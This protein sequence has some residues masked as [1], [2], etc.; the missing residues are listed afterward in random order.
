MPMRRCVASVVSLLCLCAAGPAQ[1]Q[2]CTANLLSTADEYGIAGSQFEVR[3]TVIWD[4]DGAGPIQPVLVALAASSINSQFGQVSSA[5]AMWDGTRWTAVPRVG[6]AGQITLLSV[7][8][9]KLVVGGNFTTIDNVAANRIAVFDG[10]T[11]S[12]LAAGL[13]VVPVCALEHQGS[14]YV[15]GPF[16]TVGP[17]AANGIVRWDGAQWRS[18][19][20]GVG[21]VSPPQV[22]ALTVDGDTIIAAGIF[23]TAGAVVASSVAR[24]TPSLNAWQPV[25]VW[26]ATGRPTSV[27]VLNGDVYIAG[28]GGAVAPNIPGMLRLSGQ[29]WVPVPGFEG[30]S[31]A[32]SLTR[33]DNTLHIGMLTGS[34]DSAQT[35]YCRYDG[36]FFSHISPGASLDRVNAVTTFQDR[37]IVAGEF[38]TLGARGCSRNITALGPFGQEPLGQGLS[39]VATPHVRDLL[40]NGTDTYI[41]GDFTAIGGRNI[42]YLARR[43]AAGNYESLGIDY[44]VV[45]IL[46]WDENP[47]DPR[48]AEL[49]AIIERSAVQTP[50]RWLVVRLRD[51]RWETLMRVLTTTSIAQGPRMA[52]YQGDL[53]LVGQFSQILNNDN[54]AVTAESIARYRNGRWLQF[55]GGLRFGNNPATVRAVTEFQGQLFIGGDISAANNNGIPVTNAARWNGT[56]WVAANSATAMFDLQVFDNRLYATVNAQLVVWDPGLLAWT[57]VTALP[58]G[59]DSN[60]SVALG[61]LFVGRG[62]LTGTTLAVIDGTLTGT[63][64]AIVDQP[65]GRILIAGQGLTVNAPLRNIPGLVAWAPPGAVPVIVNPPV[66]Q[67]VCLGESATLAIGVEQTEQTGYRWFRNDQPVVNTRTIS[68]ADTSTLHFSAVSPADTGTYCVVVTNACGVLTSS[69]VTLALNPA[70][71]SACDSID[72]NGNG[73]FPEEQDIIDFF[74]VLA[75]GNC[76]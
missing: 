33:I 71:P 47:A 7:Y 50:N 1:A 37:I 72:F 49:V 39:F 53:M 68:G 42:R 67:S 45:Q 10:S 5:L 16:T 63:V 61:S 48:P 26:T 66:S 23:E 65:D 64:R 75:G 60:L 58:G 22:S 52:I 8:Q 62:R 70:C 51:G 31:S 25:G 57:A 20:G 18:L 73:V 46:L 29:T 12:P 69:D 30:A 17:V 41:A 54:F 38:G 4:R 15:G 2:P 59:S 55:G 76:Q 74:S 28:A 13:P 21:G 3:Q 35:L 9:N 27:A 24:Y 40:L 43:D 44:P 6:T 56:N 32:I 34:G 19:A 11:W 36:Q 14:L